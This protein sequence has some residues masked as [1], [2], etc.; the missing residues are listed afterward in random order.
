MPYRCPHR[1]NLSS[2]SSRSCALPNI[3]AL[4][5]KDLEFANSIGWLIETIVEADFLHR[6][7]AEVPLCNTSGGQKQP[8]LLADRVGVLRIDHAG[9]AQ[10]KGHYAQA[11]GPGVLDVECAR[12]MGTPGT[13]GTHRR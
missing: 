12:W 8:E 6:G 13:G 9:Q 10:G 11:Q 4:K 2:Q 3:K 1:L 5:D 7:V